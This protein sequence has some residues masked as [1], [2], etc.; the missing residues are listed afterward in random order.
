MANVSVVGS[1]WG[2]EGKGKVVDVYG[3]SA[4]LI[5]RF[6]GGNNAGHTIVVDGEKVVLH[7]IPA[8]ALHENKTCIIGNG[9]VV[10]PEVL[11][12]EVD[13]LKE[14]GYLKSS[15]LLI[16]DRA[17]V[18]MPY[19][20]QLD[21]LRESNTSATT[22]GT[23]GRGIGPAYS[24]K[25]GRRGIRMGDL[26]RPE[27]LEKRLEE[28]LPEKNCI[29]QSYFNAAPLE[30]K[31]MMDQLLTYGEKLKDRIVD[32]QPIVHTALDE[33]KKVMYEGAQGV[34]LDIDHGTYPYVT[35]SNTITGAALSGIGVGPKD[36][37]H[38]IG[39]T[40]VY[41]TRVGEGPFPTELENETGALIQKVG[42]EFGATTGRKRR[43]GWLDLVAL[44]HAKR[45]SGFTGLALTKIDVL[46]VVKD[47]KVCIAYEIDGEQVDYV[48]SSPEDYER[49]KPIYK[50]F[51]AWPEKLPETKDPKQMPKELQEY[52][53]YIEEQLGVPA[54]LL[55]V[56]PDRNDTIIVE[57]PFN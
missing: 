32:I 33:G 50:T 39:I 46:G 26:L 56:G 36:V 53:S 20:K 34:L 18:I 24:D 51:P 21:K 40:K 25:V 41:T 12:H 23:T 8:A 2:D 3:E 48:P 38:V 52:I 28:I 22:I 31:S 15:S 44:K 54:V 17:H 6:Q 30:A 47:I 35:S 1:Q 16:S 49:V 4:D 14:K 10:D 42:G 11:L 43:C 37:D 7:L 57:N 13:Q 27:Y 19:H 29:L 9:V 45:V 55:S 5:I